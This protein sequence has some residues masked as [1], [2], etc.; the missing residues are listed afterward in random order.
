M[1]LSCCSISGI[2]RGVLQVWARSL[3]ELLKISHS[4]VRHSPRLL[5]SCTAPGSSDT[6]SRTGFGSPRSER[7][8]SSKQPD[9][10]GRY[11]W[12]AKT[13]SPTPR[14]FAKAA[15]RLGGAS[16]GGDRIPAPCRT[17]SL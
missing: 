4:I 3:E 14:H 17:P 10:V 7:I 2:F 12:K 6:L 8:T 11:D 13:S 9:I 16:A 15:Q 1:L 5:R